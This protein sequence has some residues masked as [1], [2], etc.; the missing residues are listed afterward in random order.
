[1]NLIEYNGQEYS[2]KNNSIQSASAYL[3]DSLPA[4]ELSVD[5]LTA[6]VL[7]YRLQTR[8]CA[9]DGML[10]AGDGMLCVS[11]TDSV[12][13]SQYK[14]GDVV[15]FSHKDSLIGKFYLK[16][17]M[18]KA[19][20][21]YQIFAVSA[22]GLLITDYY[23]GGVYSGI[24]LSELISNIVGGIFSYTIDSDFGSLP[25]YGWLGKSIRR[26]ALRDVLFAMGGQ[27]TKDRNGDIVIGPHTEK[28][29]YELTEDEIYIGGSL[30]N[31]TPATAIKLTE[32][33]FIALD[34]DEETTLFDGEAAAEKMTTPNGA[35]VIGILVDF[36]EPMHDLQATN[37]EILES[38]ANYAV[39]SQSP[40]ATLTGKKYTH[41]ERIL[42]RTAN[43]NA[44]PNVVQSSACSLVNLLNSENVAD[45]LIAYYGSAK[46]ATTDIVLT[47]QKT[48]DAV[49]FIDPFGDQTQGYISDLDIAVSSILKARATIISGYI[50]T[51]SGNYYSNV[52]I[53]TS[54]MTW[55]VPSE[56]KGKIRAVL[57]GG[58]DGGR[59]G[60]DGGT[61]G[62]STSTW[63]EPGEGGASG[64]PGSGGKIY[65]ITI[66]V[67]A[68]QEFNVKIGTGGLGET[69]TSFETS[70][71]E[72]TFGGYS[73]SNGLPS[74]S[75]YIDLLNGTV[76]GELGDSGVD[77]ASG[78]SYNSESQP[79]EYLGVI[80][81]P[82]ERGADHSTGSGKG[83]FGGGAAAGNNG[84]NGGNAGSS[85]GGSGGKGADAVSPVAETTP[86]KGGTGGNG[87]GGGG[88]IGYPGYSVYGE[89]S[90]GPGGRGSDGGDGAPG[91]VLIYY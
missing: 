47:S 7:D 89:N 58:G 31:T 90:P 82:G 65:I 54:D 21:S 14:Y 74:D 76:Y 17:I 23:Y 38:G 36:S 86:G 34:T 56:C 78:G 62:F 43:T 61:S 81:Y 75:G 16:S 42:T 59:K 20:F 44:S 29:P 50:P 69:E 19:K 15:K 48:G 26:D 68:G 67:S 64:D 63:Q 87:G 88:I 28:T 77:G 30:T 70:G 9:A 37:V 84:G 11:K 6:T 39:L 1:M 32:H 41:I 18:Q 72:T 60:N 57:I 12:G 8:L 79:I 13:L 45:R 51:S 83:G 24:T 27:I 91:I 85:W 71:G 3:G 25:V 55:S 80:Y 73:S 66:S 22:M 53:I 35:S 52:A 2:S 40:S 49:S 33:T 10:C 4:D 46:S 5:T